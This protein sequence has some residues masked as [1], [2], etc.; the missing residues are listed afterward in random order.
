MTLASKIRQLGKVTIDARW[1]PF[2]LQ[3]RFMAPGSRTWLGGLV[4]AKL[5]P[6]AAHSLARP[7]ETDSRIADLV[8]V[9]LSRLG[10]L[11]TAEQAAE[12]RAYF[13]Q[14]PVHDPYSGDASTFLP[15]SAERNPNS[16]I[17]HHHP[18]DIV[19]AP[20]LFSIA[21]RPDILAIVEGLLGCKP[22][23]GYLATWWSYH[24]G[25]G[26]Q[27]A[28]HFHRDVDDWRFVKLFIYLTDVGPDNGPH[29]YVAHS[30]NSPKLRQIRRFT[31]QEVTEAFGA[32]RVIEMTARA[33]EGFLEDTFGIHKG[34]PVAKG[35]RLIFQAVYSM[36][37]LPYGPKAPVI[38]AREAVLDDGSQPDPWINRL[39]LESI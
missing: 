22:T 13:L 4:A 38:S 34:Q 36:Y 33:G 15:D 23:L 6:P 25:N 12:L 1:W 2:Y 3:R 30:S 16:H 9:G 31:D 21:N 10:Q 26:A 39:Y 17:T 37:P 5:R 35:A 20:Y 14:K 24:T 18:R 27:Q 32:D 29:I 19:R 7:T 28:E 11:L 8:T